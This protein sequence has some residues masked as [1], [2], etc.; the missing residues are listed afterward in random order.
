MLNDKKPLPVW[1]WHPDRE[2]KLKLKLYK[3]F[4]LNEGLKNPI[5]G[6]A[7]TGG[8]K[9]SID[10]VQIID[11][12]EDPENVCKFQYARTMPLKPGKHLIEINIECQNPMPKHPATSFAYDRTVGCIAWLEADN[13]RL[14]TDETW[15]ADSENA[16]EIC[17]I[18]QEPYGDLDDAPEDFARSGFGDLVP[19]PIMFE[20]LEM[21]SVMFRQQ[22]ELLRVSG[23]LDGKF[24]EPLKHNELI[25]IY[26]LRKQED[27]RKLHSIQKEM[28]M[29]WTPNVL[30]DLKQESNARLRVK[31][32]GPEPVKI[33]WNGAESL[34]ELRNY[35]GC[36]TEIL[37]V[38]IGETKFSV[39]AGMRYVAI[40]I[41]GKAGRNFELEIL[42]ESIE[43]DIKQE[44]TFWCDDE[45]LN[46]I[47]EVSVHTNKLCNQLALWDGIKRDRLPWVYDLYLAARGAYPLWNDFSILKRSLLELGNT[48]YGEWMNSIPSYTLWWFASIWEYIMHRSDIDFVR[49]IAPFIQ[50]HADWVSQNVDQDGF[51]KVNGSFIDWVPISNEE[52]QIALQA[53][54]VIAKQSI[55]NIAEVMPELNIKYN[56]QIP[57]IPEEKFMNSSAVITKVLGILSGYVGHERALEFFK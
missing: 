10:G 20:L 27:W 43:A 28:D 23:I 25:S 2:K 40:F 9:V 38:G 42:C 46:K 3:S 52:S 11:L 5:F 34:F 36:M 18:G 13:F 32:I 51:L 31:N 8:A 12:L 47:Y 29:T 55:R 41:L 1:V 56:W 7:L 49:E 44:G 53:I 54:Y 35:D 26:H 22:D 21:N 17:K 19:K 33:L 57:N 16:E 6:I 50:R 14:V 39:P 30:L 37:D 48:P 45:Q 24:I 15:L 4:S